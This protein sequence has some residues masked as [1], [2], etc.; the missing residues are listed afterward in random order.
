[1]SSSAVVDTV[2]PSWTAAFIARYFGQVRHGRLNIELPT[3]ERLT[4]QGD[5]PGEEAELSLH[6]WRG[7]W[8]LIFSGDIG[9]GTGYRDGDWSSLNLRSLFVWTV[10]NEQSLA[11]VSGGSLAGRIMTVLRH[12]LRSN[13]RTNSRRNIADHYDLGNEFYSHWLDG[14]MNYSSG[15]YGL[16]AASLEQAQSNKNERISGLLDLS[17]GERVLEIG[18]GWGALAEHLISVH[19]CHVTGLTLSTRQRDYAIERLRCL[20]L[21]RNAEIRLQDYRDVQGQFD[22]IVSVEMFEAVGEAYWPRY[23][24]QL[25]KCLSPDGVA[26]LQ[27]ITIEARKFNSY[28]RQPDFIQ[29]HIFPGGMLPTDGIVREHVERAGLALERVETFG[30]SYAV[31]LAAWRRRFEESWG[32]IAALG[33]DERFK[34]LWNYYLVYCETGFESGSLD[35]AHYKI[36]HKRP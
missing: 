14:G 34:R 35:V 25:N 26:V 27:V 5:L 23:F 3:G 6:R 7:L 4:L 18:C 36:K 32:E 21:G 20:N 15:L 12:R 19:G 24:S 22:R 30:K 8:R 31:T 29:T 28:R 13:T 1:M 17:G 9:F 11:T 33:F 2:R 16:E 10:Q